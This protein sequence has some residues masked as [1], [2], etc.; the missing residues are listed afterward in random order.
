MSA[1]ADFD[2]CLRSAGFPVIAGV[3]EAGRGPLAGPVIAAVVVMRA[4]SHVDGVRD[5]KKLTAT[6]REHLLFEII[7]RSAEVSIGLAWQD[8]IDAANI[9]VASLA[10]MSR[11][12]GGLTTKPSAILV[13]GRDLPAMPFPGIALVKGDG[14]S[15]CV[16][17]ASI[18][19]KVVR[20]ALMCEYH[21]LYPQYGFNRHKGYPTVE[22]LRRLAEWG[23]C[24]IHRR[25]FHGVGWG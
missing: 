15:E 9:R 1:L 13:D 3:D 11:A 10:A 22:H 24:A 7:R 19:A 23:P 2:D 5:S 14:R 16:A 17:A 12:V 8:E 20:D 4:S 21:V 6:V 18:V 25:T